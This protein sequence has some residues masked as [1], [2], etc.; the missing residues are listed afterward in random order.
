MSINQSSTV[1]SSI[2]NR[3][4]VTLMLVSF[5]ISGSFYLVQISLSMYAISLGASITLAGVIVGCFS[6]TSLLARPFSGIVVNRLPKKRVLMAAIGLMLVSSATYALIRIPVLLIAVR[7]VHGVGFA[8]NSTVSLVLASQSVPPDRMG[9]G[10]SYFGLAQMLSSA[11]MPTL[12]A[13]LTE[14]WGTGIVF[15]VATG[16]I[17]VGGISVSLLKF[18]EPALIRTDAPGE[19]RGKFSFAEMISAPL[20]PLGILGGL[21]SMFNGLNSSFMLPVGMDRG[22]AN[23]AYYFTVNTSTII[24]IRLLLGRLA[25]RKPLYCVLVP[26]ILS[27]VIAAVLIGWAASLQVILIAAV[28]QAAGQGMAQPSLQAECIKRTDAQHRGTASST[29]YM[30]VDTGQGL[31]TM[32]GGAVSDNWGYAAMYYG[33]AAIFVGSFLLYVGTLLRRKKNS[34]AKP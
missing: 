20:L 32:I 12:G 7:V 19:T 2:F 11:F 8:L 31:G 15:P 3:R 16:I 28:L 25:D 23:I 10:V 26:A 29:Y 14:R 6:I 18:E 4:Y 27:A 13:W 1:K 5:F 24:L 17:L 34:P 9:E 22:I 21:F 30:C 33:I